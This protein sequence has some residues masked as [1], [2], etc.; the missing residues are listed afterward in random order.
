MDVDA[1]DCKRSYLG[2]CWRMTTLPYVSEIDLVVVGTEQWY[3]GY[4]MFVGTGQSES[5]QWVHDFESY[6][7]WDDTFVN[8]TIVPSMRSK[9]ITMKTMHIVVVVVVVVFV[10]SCSL[11]SWWND[12]YTIVP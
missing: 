2:Y 5:I 9:I 6:Y 12:R 1:I 3:V 11:Y 8:P 7:Y 4:H 10:D